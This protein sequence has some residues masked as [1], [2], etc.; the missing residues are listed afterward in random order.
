MDRMPTIFGHPITEPAAWTAID[1]TANRSWGISLTADEVADLLAACAGVRETGL[2]LAQIGA[3]NFPLPHC[4]ATIARI[5]Q[6]LW[7]GRGDGK[8]HAC[9]QT[10]GAPA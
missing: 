4:R 5:R 3:G 9:R 8:V 7:D 10:D 2:P 1:L 6:Q